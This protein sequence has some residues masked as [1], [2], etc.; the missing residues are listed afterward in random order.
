MAIALICGSSENWKR[1][2]AQ[3]T[4]VENTK[5]GRN[6]VKT[7]RNEWKGA[8]TALHCVERCESVGSLDYSL[9]LM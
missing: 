4:N 7:D 6:G 9:V 5:L 1:G 3:A 8:T 2:R